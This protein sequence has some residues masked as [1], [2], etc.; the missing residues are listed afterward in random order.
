MSEDQSTAE[1]EAKILPVLERFELMRKACLKKGMLISGGVW[2]LAASI[3]TYFVFNSDSP[4]EAI[5]IP[6]IVAVFLSVIV[7]FWVTRSYKSGFKNEVVRSVVTAYD[8]NLSYQPTGLIPQ[9]SFTSSRL[10]LK[11]IDRYRGED[12]VSGIRG[13][14]DFEFSEIH[15][16]YKTTT[17]D[18]KGRTQTQWHTIFKGV[19][20]IADFHK[21]FRTHTVVLP[22]TAEKLF[23]FL[24]KKLQSMNFMRGDLIKLEDPEFEEEFCVYGSDQIE[25]RYILSPSLMRRILDCK[26]KFQSKIYLAF[27]NSKVYLAIETRKNHFEPRIFKPVNDLS[28]VNEFRHDL[29][30]IVDVVDDLNLNTRIWSKE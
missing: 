28:L 26:A 16:E 18:S 11:G 12:Y 15:A 30:L 10:F 24:G 23:G 20:F 8:S 27:L 5:I 13:K 25:A 4:G 29:D 9:H 3:G 6:T 22:D 19:F 2:A 1:F 14:T 17:R 7:F 21:D